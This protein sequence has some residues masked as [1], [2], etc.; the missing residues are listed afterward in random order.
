M[1]IGII[2]AGPRGISVALY[3]LFA[4]LD[5]TIIDSHPTSSWSSKK[6][7]PDLQM[8]SPL[9]FDLVTY[10]P[11]L[12]EFS[13]AH[14]LGFEWDFETQL[15]VET[16]ET[17][18]MRSEFFQYLSSVWNLI[19][20]KITLIKKRVI[21]ISDH[22][23]W[24]E[25]RKNPLTFD[26]L[27]IASGSNSKPKIPFWL[28]FT[29][30]KSKIIS[31]EKVLSKNYQDRSF[32]IIGS[33]QGAAEYTAYLS[34]NNE[35]TSLIKKTPKVNRY[36]A[37]SYFDWQSASALGNYYRYLPLDKRSTYLSRI[38]QWQPSITPYIKGVL[39]QR[40]FNT[41]P[42]ESLN[43]YQITDLLDKSE[44]IL[45]QTGFN[46]DTS[47][48]PISEFIERDWELSQFPLLNNFQLKEKPIF[49]TGVLATAFDGPR[50]HSLV[51]AGL[52]AKS[53]INTI[54]NL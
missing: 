52:T 18:V 21:S 49:L 37:P 10:L 30:F 13:L 11:E 14:F 47:M 16:N 25:H 33:G 46:P 54:L 29:P 36:P 5:V 27:V 4:G 50:Q 26:Y 24:V 44:F 12:K 23:V 48:L 28:E 43:S 38:K 17:P 1:R 31:T 45:I 7:L 8:R 35:V 40:R 2:G 6:M 20:P 32:L 9:S 22:S 42:L 53:I 3:A 39:D 41:I 19:L 51:S 15:K 34:Q